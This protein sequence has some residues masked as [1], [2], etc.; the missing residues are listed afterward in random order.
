MLGA[1]LE[2]K[3]SICILPGQRHDVPSFMME[4]KL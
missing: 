2:M 1:V 3:A 4:E